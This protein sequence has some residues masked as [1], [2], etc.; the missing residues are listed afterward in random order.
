MLKL[1]QIIVFLLKVEGHRIEEESW[2]RVVSPFPLWWKEAE[3]QQKT[4]K[5]LKASYTFKEL[6]Q[7]IKLLQVIPTVNI[8]NNEMGIYNLATI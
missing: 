2:L 1:V 6:Q 3:T 5:F 4:K 8:I 7:E